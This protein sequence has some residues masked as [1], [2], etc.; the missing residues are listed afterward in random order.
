MPNKSASA[1]PQKTAGDVKVSSGDKHIVRVIDDMPA[2]VSEADAEDYKDES[3]DE[4]AG[5]SSEEVAAMPSPVE[6]GKKQLSVASST[7]AT[8]NSEQNRQAV[9]SPTVRGVSEAKPR[10]PV[11]ASQ[12][13]ITGG[14]QPQISV[15]S[16]EV[17]GVGRI[18]TVSSSPEPGDVHKQ[19]VEPSVQNKAVGKSR[20]ESAATVPAP[21]QESGGK[22][23]PMAVSATVK[24]AS[25]EQGRQSAS[26]PM[27]KG[28]SEAKSRTHASAS[29]QINVAS[30][31][32][33]M[34]VSSPS[35]KTT[36]VSQSK[37]PVENK[38]NKAAEPDASVLRVKTVTE[39]SIPPG[40]AGGLGVVFG[41]VGGNDDEVMKGVKIKIEGTAFSDY[42]VTDEDGFFEFGNLAAGNYTITQEKLDYQTQRIVIN[43]EEGEVVDL[44]TIALGT[45]RSYIFG[46]VR[47][48]IRGNPIGTATIK[49]KG[50]KTKSKNTAFTD[51]DGFFKFADLGEDTYLLIARK[52]GFKR[53][54]R[55]IRLSQGEEREL[56][57]E[58]RVR[59]QK[60]KDPSKV[61]IESSKGKV[62][63]EE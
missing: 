14:E 19:G 36:G 54:N 24:T 60:E 31:Q 41:L 49:L 23:Q 37:A 34:V 63:E 12:Q 35:A 16:G 62:L 61:T 5:E 59:A 28:T 55:T 56:E 11:S 27:A 45:T 48:S 17:S 44:G 47:D 15:S 18:V 38:G 46:Y 7:T 2:V 9:T 29:S 42:A 39:P 51:T 21:V 30:E 1:S 6:G 8:A 58:M 25:S 10:T 22:K 52:R 13:K 32:P 50:L 40:K 33:Q 26:S 57:L 53:L 4:V 3:G 20:I 43:L